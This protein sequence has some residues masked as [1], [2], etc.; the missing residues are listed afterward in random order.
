MPA[1]VPDPA[2]GTRAAVVSL[3]FALAVTAL[4][5]LA[6]GEAWVLALFPP[7]LTAVFAG[8]VGLLVILALAVAR[9]DAAVALGVLLLA[10]VRV[11]PAPSDAVFAVV[12]GLAFVTGRL[13]IGRIPPV[14]LWLSGAYLAVNLFA[15]IEVID[16]RRAVQF[17][18]ISLYLVVFGLWFATY[19]SST[20]QARLVTRAYLFAAVLS[21]LAA[22]LALFVA[23]PGHSV[24]V[25]GGERAQG[26]FKDPLVFAPYLV[27]AAL[28]LLEELVQPRL[29]GVGRAWKTLFVTILS[30]G[31]LFSFSRAAWLN[32]ALGVVVLLAVLALRRGGG[33]RALAIFA[34]V[35]TTATVS[36]GALAVSG[37]VGFL[38]QRAHL[39]GY[40]SERF[41][42]Q[43][44]GLREGERYPL[45]IGPGQF[46][47][48][49]PLSVHSTYIRAFAEAG[50]PGVIALGGLLLATLLLAARNV[51]RGSDTYGI[52]S[53]TLLA[54]WC[55][56]LANSLFVDTLHWRHL[57]VVAALIWAGSM[58]LSRQRTRD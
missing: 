58:R 34:V 54:A 40:D 10:V 44:L 16:I 36:V 3:Q 57:W 50:V 42:A 17:F 39:Q 8:G 6:A 38:E 46:E 52:G 51:V 29:L 14:V 32:L 12:I 55:G 56:I 31:V 13:V 43:A 53:A 30:L 27:P 35:I 11:E 37:S 4:V 26:L 22:S 47:V 21:A 18:G 20:R 7:S 15:S 28:L 25:Y 48:V 5:V 9:P 45:G 24:L 41:G 1:L 19:V 23:F 33:R 49:S 2:L